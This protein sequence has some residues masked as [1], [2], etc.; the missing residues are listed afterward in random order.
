MPATGTTDEK[1]A[2]D[3]DVRGETALCGF[4]K[5]HHARAERALQKVLM[6]RPEVLAFAALGP[7]PAESSDE[8]LIAEHQ[9]RLEQ[10]TRPVSGEEAS[11]L[12]DLFGVDECHGLA[13]SLVHLNESAPGAGPLKSRAEDTD[14]DW[15]RRLWAR[16][17]G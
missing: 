11:V 4:T 5:H 10:V 1:P 9:F 6:I 17:R 14:N 3:H 13:W 12:I 15:H 2:A 7:L 16:R 8:Q